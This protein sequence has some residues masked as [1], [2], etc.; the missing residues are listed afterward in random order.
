MLFKI[1]PWMGQPE[2]HATEFGAQEAV[3]KW[4]RFGD[5]RVMIFKWDAQRQAYVQVDTVWGNMNTADRTVNFGG[6]L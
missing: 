2:Y 4:E 6:G 1:V 3:T 5:R